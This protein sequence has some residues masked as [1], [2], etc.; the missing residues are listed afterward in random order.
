MLQFIRYN[1]YYCMFVNVFNKVIEELSTFIIT[2]FVFTIVFSFVIILMQADVDAEGDEYKH[3]P[4][5][6]Q[7]FV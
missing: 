1:E 7:S 4:M 5:L 2:F 6:F 3:L